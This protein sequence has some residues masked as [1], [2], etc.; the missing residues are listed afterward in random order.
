MRFSQSRLLHFGLT[1]PMGIVSVLHIIQAVAMLTDNVGT[2]TIIGL[3]RNHPGDWVPLA[4]GEPLLAACYAGF[5]LLAFVGMWFSRWPFWAHCS[6]WAPQQLLI[7]AGGVSAV[8]AMWTGCYLDGTCGISI[9]HL[10]GDQ[11]IYPL[12]AVMHVA[13]FVVWRYIISQ[14]EHYENIAH[15][16]IQN[17]RHTV[18][19]V[20]ENGG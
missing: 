20:A 3:A 19:R 1:L 10:V 14:M 7:I 18:N 2:T 11:A 15:G 13:S 12:L 6:L 17:I 16:Y 8:E 9:Q 5:A 4:L